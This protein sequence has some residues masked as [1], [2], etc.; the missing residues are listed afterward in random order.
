MTQLLKDWLN[1][2][3]NNTNYDNIMN[4]D[5][6]YQLITTGKGQYAYTGKPL[7]ITK[8]ACGFI[9]LPSIFD[10]TNIG[11]YDEQPD[12][13]VLDKKKLLE[14]YGNWEVTG[15]EMN[16]TYNQLAPV[17]TNFEYDRLSIVNPKGD[18][19]DSK[20]LLFLSVSVGADI[21]AGYTPNCVAIFDNFLGDHTNCEAWLN[22][23]YEI[24]NGQASVNDKLYDFS[25]SGRM[26]QEGCDIYLEPA[27]S[28][29]VYDSLEYQL[30][31]DIDNPDNIRD[32]LS[33]NVH[34]QEHLPNTV[35]IKKINYESNLMN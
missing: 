10:K 32:E 25:I 11:D 12:A 9:T 15:Y 14:K 29:D 34:H 20:D 19:F 6:F 4:F 7:P 24:A 27:K 22:N 28:G 26:T 21:R 8:P 30:Y 31:A 2:P 18:I 5:D 23:I 3:E 33:E 17:E 16:N 35:K 1:D 13:W